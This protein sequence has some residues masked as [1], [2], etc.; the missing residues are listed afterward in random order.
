MG[1]VGSNDWMKSPTVSPT[2]IKLAINIDMVGR[3]RDGKLQVLGTRSGYGLRRLVAGPIDPALQLEFPWELTGNSDHWPFV[4][5]QI[6]VVMLHTGLH[7]DYHRPGD[8]AEKVNIEG[9][10]AVSGYLRDIVMEVADSEWLPAYRPARRQEALAAE[11]HNRSRFDSLAVAQQSTSPRP[12]L[13]IS[14][15][16]D[17]AEPASVQLTDVLKDSPAAHAGL[18]TEDRLYGVNGEAFADG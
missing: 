6:P 3:L 9:L 13:G 14:W 10:A 1:L 8:D 7:D 12:R 4:E 16:T 17:E 2:A 5:R 15:R 18:A 11:R